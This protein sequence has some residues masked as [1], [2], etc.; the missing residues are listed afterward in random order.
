MIALEFTSSAELKQHYAEGRARLGFAP[1]RRQTAVARPVSYEASPS[2][3]LAVLPAGPAPIDFIASN[4]MRFLASYAAAKFRVD[5]KSLWIKY[6]QD[7]AVAARQFAMALISAHMDTSTTRIG[8]FFGVDHSTVMKARNKRF[9]TDHS[10]RKMFEATE[11]EKNARRDELDRDVAAC[12]GRA[13]TPTDIAGRL[14]VDIQVV[15]SAIGR[16]RYRSTSST[17]SAAT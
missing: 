8:R 6:R 13:M 14:S 10:L 15:R 17:R 11:A 2:S 1:V 5:Y 7:E 9:R 3:V 12:L 4:G 16:L